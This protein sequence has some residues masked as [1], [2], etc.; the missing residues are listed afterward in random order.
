M[1]DKGKISIITPAY[2]AAGTIKK[3]IESV[4]A[5]TYS[6]W[7]MLII[8]DG[9]IDNTLS[10][11]NTIAEKDN[12][13]KVYHIENGGVSKARNYAIQKSSGTFITCVDSD[14]WIES[15]M[16]ETLTKYMDKDIEMVCGNFFYEQ[17]NKTDIG[18]IS[19]NMIYKKEI[20]ALPLGVLIPESIEHFNNISIKIDIIGAACCKLYKREL[21]DKNSINYAEGVALREDALFNIQCFIHATNIIIINKPLYHYILTPQSSNFRYRPDV[22]D[23]NIIFFKEY[24]KIS[25]FI[26][27][28]FKDLFINYVSYNAYLSLIGRYI[29]HKECKLSYLKKV[30]LLNTYLKK[31]PIYNIKQTNNVYLPIYK[32]IELFCLQHKLAFLLVLIQKIKT[33]YKM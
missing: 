5:Q 33:I 18:Y 24:S 26:D 16:L 8:D 12:R 4:Q 3:C 27:Q 29:G 32:Q 11:C 25:P 20:N 13:I 6:N 10:I 19:K 28:K 14:D 15:I 7:E 22:H 21:I 31:Y 30:K 2:N 1:I 9:S 23:Q 17:P